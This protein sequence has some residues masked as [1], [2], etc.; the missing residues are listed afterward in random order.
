MYLRLTSM[1]FF[2]W[3]STRLTNLHFITRLQEKKKQ[4]RW[5]LQWFYEAC[6]F[7][8]IFTVFTKQ[9]KSKQCVIALSWVK[10]SRRTSIKQYFSKYFFNETMDRLDKGR[11]ESDCCWWVTFRQAR[12]KLSWAVTLK[13]TSA[14]VE[15]ASHTNNSSFQDTPPTDDHTIRTTD[16][17]VLEPFTVNGIILWDKWN[18]L[19]R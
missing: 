7:L 19:V 10:I 12:Q 14:Y 9:R 17:S 11:P 15:E 16:T 13:M 4:M 6:G 5:R 18:H 3:S 8:W 1:N 2:I